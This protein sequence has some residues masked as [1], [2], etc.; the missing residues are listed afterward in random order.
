M[1]DTPPP[2]PQVS[3]VFFAAYQSGVWALKFINPTQA[4]VDSVWFQHGPQRCWQLLSWSAPS[5][6]L[7]YPTEKVLSH[8]GSRLPSPEHLLP[9]RQVPLFGSFCPIL[10]H[11]TDFP[12]PPSL[13]PS[14]ARSIVCIRLR[15]GGKEGTLRDLLLPKLV[16]N[17]PAVRE[18]WAWSLGWE[19]P[20]EKGKATHSSILA[21]R[22][23]WTVL[24]MGLQRVRYDWMT[25]TQSVT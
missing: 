9:I 16:N 5:L 20:L 7:F 8:P 1:Y 6:S 3:S 24:S 19:D 2:L 14:L 18:A 25:F 10:E 15:E 17:A 13:D 11:S 4:W 23:Q 22:I 21:W 12:D